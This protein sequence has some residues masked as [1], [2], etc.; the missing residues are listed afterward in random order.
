MKK[1]RG[2]AKLKTLP[3][4]LQEDLWQQLR[5]THQ[6]KAQAWLLEKHGVKTSTGALS[7]FYSWYPRQATLRSAAAT[8][9]ELE[10]TL[11]KMPE[12]EITADKARKV[13]QV[14]FEIQAARDRDPALFSA[15]RKGSLDERR[16][17][18][19]E[20][21]FEHAKKEDWEHGLDALF[22]EVKDCPPALKLFEA[23]KAEI[24][25]ARS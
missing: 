1:P 18:L 22:E 21:K 25:K 3:D 10:A 11:R 19:E 14:N 8:S 2:D 7:D 20:A 23:M 12:L 24:K 15:L 13:A 5:R 17:V 9:D 16:Q 6:V 4:A